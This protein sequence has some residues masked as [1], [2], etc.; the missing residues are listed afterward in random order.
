VAAAVAAAAAE[1]FTAE[2]AAADMAAAA[3]DFT[4]AALVD[5]TAAAVAPG[6]VS[7]ARHRS[8]HP[9]RKPDRPVRAFQI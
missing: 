8:I 9:D 1:V 4:G 7:I 6:Q 5:I 2:G 3:V